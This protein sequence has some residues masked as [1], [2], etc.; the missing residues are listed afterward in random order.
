M[1][2]GTYVHLCPPSSTHVHYR[3]LF[4]DFLTIRYMKSHTFQV[5]S[6]DN[7]STLHRF[8]TLKLEGEYS[9][10]EIKRAI[11]GQSCTIN[12]KLE[13]FGSTK[14]HAGDKV[15]FRPIL[16][17]KVQ[18]TILFENDRFLAIDKWPGL[19]CEN[20]TVQKYF[21]N[22][23]LIHRLDKDTSGVLLLAKSDRVLKEFIEDFR[24]KLVKKSY[25]AICQGVVKQSKGV[26]KDYL[27]SVGEF[28]GQTLYS[29]RKE[30][31]GEPAETHWFIQEVKG[32]YSLVQCNPI[33]GRTHQLRVHL[34][35]LGMPIAGDPLY[36]KLAVELEVPRLMLHAWKLSLPGGVTIESRVPEDF[37]RAWKLAGEGS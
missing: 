23:L 14:L 8:L 28:Q 24:Q 33:T 37:K 35:G 25:L 6:E 27:Y 16:K 31:P 13:R 30:L 5:Q 22:T 7:G 29:G 32:G 10:K 12:G 3:P 2:D 4:T 11:E 21:P 1:D 20:P 9:G 19:V 34:K 18:P 36:N 26:I 17:E 15:T